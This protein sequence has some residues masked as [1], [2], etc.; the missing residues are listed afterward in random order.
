MRGGACNFNWISAGALCACLSGADAFPHPPQP[1]AHPP[2]A[3][4]LDPNP[5]SWL[6][7]RLPTDTAA[8]VTMARA[9]IC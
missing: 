5:R 6:Q 7:S 2:P 3:L 4:G 8:T 1:V 9:A